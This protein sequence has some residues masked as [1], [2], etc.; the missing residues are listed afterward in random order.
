M[1]SLS[2]IIELE[3]HPGG[4][5]KIVRRVGDNEHY[6]REGGRDF[7]DYV[8]SVGDLI[9]THSSLSETTQIIAGERDDLLTALTD[10]LHYIPHHIVIKRRSFT[11]KAFDEWMERNGSGE[12]DWIDVIDAAV[13]IFTLESDMILFRVN[14]NGVIS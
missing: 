12:H 10:V 3:P 2:S 8:S 7:D 9:G 13:L 11:R 14:F 5:E 6:A 4:S 1:S